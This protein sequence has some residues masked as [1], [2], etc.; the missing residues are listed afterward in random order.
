MA[1]KFIQKANLQK[2]ALHRAMGI[3][4]GSK[5]PA[6]KLQAVISRLHAKAEKGKLSASES[7]MLKMANLAK[8][9]KKMH[10]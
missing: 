10:A 9:L 8:T 4:A 7:R 6:A 1:E 2:G 3:P 5:I